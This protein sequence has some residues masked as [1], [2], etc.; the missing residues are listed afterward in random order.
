MISLLVAATVFAND[1][2]PS[3]ASIPQNEL[4]PKGAKIAVAEDGSLTLNGKPRYFPA[5]QWY[6][7]I[8]Y[9]GQPSTN[10]E[11]AVKW[12]YEGLPNYEKMQRL[13]LDCGGFY[14][15]MAWMKRVYRPWF[16]DERRDNAKLA[17]MI[18][19]L[20]M[21][22]Y[23]DM[24]ASEWSHGSLW[25]WDCPLDPK[26]TVDPP[27][28]KKPGKDSPFCNHP[29][30]G[31]KL[32]TPGRLSAKAWTQGHAHWV[33]W[34]IVY[35]QGRDIWLNMWENIAKDAIAISPADNRPWCYELM[36]EPSCF[37]TSD[38]AKEAFAESMREKFGTIEKLNAAWAK[39][40]SGKLAFKSFDELPGAYDNPDK[41]LAYLVEYTKFIE[42]KF[43]SLLAEGA[44]RIRALDP[45]AKVTFQ[46]CTIRTHGID[47]YRSFKNLDVVCSQTGGRGIMAGALLRALA[48]GKP[49]VD[50]EMYIGNTT[51]SIRSSYLTQYIRGFNVSYSFKWESGK[52]GYY[53]MNRDNVELDRLLGSRIAKRDVMDVNEFFTPRRRG[54]EP[55]MA[56]IFSNPS[57]RV[58]EYG[59][60]GY[61]CFDQAQAVAEFEH[62][63]YEVVFEEELADRPGRLDPYRVVVA[64]GISAAYAQT[65]AEVEKWV[66]SGGT[67]ALINTRLDGNEYAGKNPDAFAAAMKSGQTLALGKGKVVAADLAN[68]EYAAFLRKVCAE[69]GIEPACTMISEE[70]GKPAGAIEAFAARKNAMMAWALN[71]NAGG[72]QLVRF[73]PL[74]HCDAPEGSRALVHVWN[75]VETVDGKPMMVSYRQKLLPNAQGEYWL[76]LAQGDV[77]F[78]VE[79]TDAQLAARYPAGKDVVW[80]EP[81]GADGAYKAGKALLDA[82][83]AARVVE[84]PVFTVDPNKC[85][86][87]DLRKFVNRRFIDKV[88]KDGRDGWVDQGAKFSLEDTPWG[89]VNC[90]GVPMDFI[91]YDQNGYRDCLVMKST[92]LVDA[93]ADE[94]PF[95]TEVKGIPV[96]AKAKNIYFLHAV[97]WGK[98]GSIETAFTYVFNYE[99]GSKVEVPCR[100]FHEVWD[101]FFIATTDD[102]TKNNCYKGWANKQNRGLYIWQWRNPQ[103]EKRVKTLDIIAG[104]GQQIP[105]IVAATVEMP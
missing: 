39:S 104:T 18:A 27:K 25:H 98:L 13:G 45:E 71:S 64:A 72:G 43:A 3:F 76:Y 5:T 75:R 86:P 22:M 50:N 48:R 40:A 30:C 47:L 51:N 90:N 1:P 54:I 32:D 68:D 73:K 93:P 24:T 77:Q 19:E 65:A 89:I 92:K 34:S 80:L 103:P 101:W 74:L 37:D 23:V 35:P 12:F 91:R 36:N 88:A 41:P 15:A 10:N 81:L 9:S 57:E 79:G 4:F 63:G 28:C 16:R 20:G 60:E 55:R 31:A 29:E 87:I 52:S 83:I 21:P 6:G 59:I 53:F 42:G 78:Y 102:M 82:E 58:A 69:A 61:K 8:E 99:D 100:N 49:I 7:Q 26:R 96:D 94:M 97:G 38:Y 14:G 84:K 62:L 2:I 17:G 67:L 33:P 44:E 46:P 70:S 95:P 66:K 85:Q 11:P 105:L 56:I